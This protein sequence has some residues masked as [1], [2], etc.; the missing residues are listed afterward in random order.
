LIDRHTFETLSDRIR[1]DPALAH[2]QALVVSQ[3][4]RIVFERHFGGT[5]PEEPTDVFSITKRRGCDWA[6]NLLRA[7][8]LDLSSAYVAEATRAHVAGGPP[9]HLPYG[10]LW[11]IDEPCFLA[12]GYAGQFVVVTPGDELVVVG[13]GDAARLSPTWTSARHALER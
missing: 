3:R 6:K 13:R 9:E 1:S 7:P 12:A 11:W 8:V 4:G 5:A 10:F 2:T